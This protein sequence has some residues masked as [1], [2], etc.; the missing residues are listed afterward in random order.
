MLL[1]TLK[2]SSAN[3]SPCI[4]YHINSITIVVPDDVT[5]WSSLNRVHGMIGAGS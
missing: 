5:W 2:L 4:I 3:H 1:Q